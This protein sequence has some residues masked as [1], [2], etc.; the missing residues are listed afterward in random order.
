MLP[1]RLVHLG[2]HGNA[3][4]GPPRSPGEVS[5]SARDHADSRMTA[6]PGDPGALAPAEEGTIARPP[7]RGRARP[8]RH[9]ARRRR[10]CGRRNGLLGTPIASGAAPRGS[11][12]RYTGRPLGREPPGSRRSRTPFRPP[13]AAAAWHGSR[14][15]RRQI[16]VLGREAANRAEAAS[17]A[18]GVRAEQLFELRRAERG[19]HGRAADPEL[20]SHDTR[21]AAWIA[22][23]DPS[24]GLRGVDGRRRAGGRGR[25]DVDH[26]ASCPAEPF[27]PGGR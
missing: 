15:Q 3:P 17:R 1:H 2:L 6:S 21:L 20:H 23:Q 12:R 26:V 10:R 24:V 22:D 14:S 25:A 18:V 16:V 9:R 19:R 13:L 11:A 8:K 5:A 4:D 27:R 7:L